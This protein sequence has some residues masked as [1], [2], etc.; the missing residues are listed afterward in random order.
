M[1]EGNGVDF[2]QEARE[3]KLV[4]AA[5]APVQP[6]GQTGVGHFAFHEQKQIHLDDDHNNPRMESLKRRANEET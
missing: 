5:V 6:L 2:R 3:A 4:S 1:V